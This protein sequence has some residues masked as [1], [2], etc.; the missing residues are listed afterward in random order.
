MHKDS[1]VKA[2]VTLAG[3]FYDPILGNY[4][5]L[6]RNDNKRNFQFQSKHHRIEKV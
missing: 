1:L 5:Y 2:Y 4:L 6:N 3:D